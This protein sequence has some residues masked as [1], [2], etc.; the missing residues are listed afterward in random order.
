[1]KITISFAT[2]EFVTPAHDEILLRLTSILHQRNIVGSFHITGDQARKLR[3]RRR[4]DVIA[5]LKQHVIGYHGNTHGA[6]P[7]IPEV[8]ENQSWDAA[9]AE[10]IRTES[11]GIMDIADIFGRLPKYYVLEFVKA[12]QL[13]YALKSLAIDLIGFSEL[14]SREN[15]PFAWYCG[16]LCFCAPHMGIEMPPM[17]QRLDHLKNDFD[18][19]YVNAQKGECE[20]VVKLFNHPYKFLY[21]NNIASWVSENNLY[22]KYDLHADWKVP[23]QSLYHQATTDALFNDFENL[24]EY[25]QSKNDVEFLS[26][27]ELMLQY[28]VKPDSFLSFETV[29]TL[30]QLLQNEF[31]YHYLDG[32]FYSPAEILGMLIESLSYFHKHGSLPKMV[33]C[34]DLLG[35]VQDYQLVD[36]ARLSMPALMEDI[37]KLNQEVDF[38]RRIPSQFTFGG[39]ALSAVDIMS[40]CMVAFSATIN[41]QTH[42]GILPNDVP[43]MGYLPR[44]AQQPHFS[45]DSFTREIYPAGFRGKEIC[46]A[47]RL[48]TWTYKPAVMRSNIATTAAYTPTR[49]IQGQPD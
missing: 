15:K 35:P 33:P 18:R 16:S 47:S 11:Q 8:C 43:N 20:G 31:S 21:N 17:P 3:E 45:E 46:I 37:V 32:V 26:T 14:P 25:I 22:Q 9:V 42:A 28:H 27:S 38:H 12:P 49:T 41:H 5:A 10:L 48:Q 4:F 29:A 34:R 24:L 23:Y 44:I 30:A 36:S 19:Y 39:T 7:F 6:W 1:M 2:E 40:H 13:I